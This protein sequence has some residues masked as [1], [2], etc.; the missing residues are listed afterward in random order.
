MNLGFGGIVGLIVVDCDSFF[1]F[2]N[3]DD[4]RIAFCFTGL[5]S[6]NQTDAGGNSWRLLSLFVIRSDDDDVVVDTPIRLAIKLCQN[7]NSFIGA[8]SAKISFK[9]LLSIFIF[10]VFVTQNYQ[11]N[12]NK[13]ADAD[14]LIKFT[15]TDVYEIW[16]QT[17]ESNQITSIKKQ[18]NKKYHW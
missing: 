6:F 4:I 1:V 15:F 11:K 14:G 18:T 2:G 12:E 7:F 13:P 17:V 8:N 9:L 16:C 5:R 3:G 10:V